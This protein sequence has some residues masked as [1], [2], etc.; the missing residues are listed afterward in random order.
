MEQKTTL[1]QWHVLD[2]VIT[3]GGFAQ[4]AKA[5]NVSQS[6][7]SYAVT[8]L[9]NSLG[10]QLLQMRGRR[11][12]LST[13]G[14]ALLQEA[15]VLLQGLRDLEDRA[16]FLAGHQETSITVAVS[17]IY[18]DQPLFDAVAEFRQEHRHVRVEL[19]RVVRLVPEQA[20]QKYN[21][22]LCIATHMPEK[23]MSD[24]LLDIRLIAVANASHPLSK[25]P[26]RISRRHLVGHLMASVGEEAGVIPLLDSGLPGIERLEV[27]TVNAAIA[28][29]Q[30]GACYGW[31][32][33]DRIFD[34]LERKE[35]VPLRMTAGSVMHIP[36]SLLK[37]ES[38]SIGPAAARMAELIQQHG[39]R[40][41]EKFTRGA[42]RKPW[43]QSE[44][45]T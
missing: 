29:I 27:S 22:H 2:T 17:S 38:L 31:L 26:T 1:Q 24:P 8:H 32:P 11:A 5:L 15:R 6:S 4:A 21:A 36:L 9:Q 35:F 42:R 7:I 13:N 3:H 40:Y 37:T 19:H 30:S 33:A 16:S 45:Y 23:Y 14:L 39:T 12:V 41:A 34:A 20:F 44:A 18:P 43:A 28:S 10:L 25:I